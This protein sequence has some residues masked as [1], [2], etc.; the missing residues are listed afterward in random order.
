MVKKINCLR[1]R[2]WASCDKMPR[3]ARF[4]R[5]SR[6][7]QMIGGEGTVKL[8]SVIIFVTISGQ[9]AKEFSL[10]VL[11]ATFNYTNNYTNAVT[12]KVL[13]RQSFLH[14][15]KSRDI[16]Y[17]AVGVIHCRK[18]YNRWYLAMLKLPRRRPQNMLLCLQLTPITTKQNHP[19]SDKVSKCC[20]LLRF[21]AIK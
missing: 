4:F 9:T 15:S 21:C 1:Q 16:P 8:K 19:P 18:M 3:M 10:K 12:L 17:F 2:H 11:C 5:L 13:L 6:K 14:F 20:V 7:K